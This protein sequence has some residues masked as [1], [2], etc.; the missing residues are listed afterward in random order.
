MPSLLPLSGPWQH[1]YSQIENATRLFWQQ[2]RFLDH[3]RIQGLEIGERLQAKVQDLLATCFAASPLNPCETF[4]LSAATLLYECGWQAPESAQKTVAERYH[5]SGSL[6]NQS[7]LQLPGAPRLGLAGLDSTTAEILVSLCAALGQSGPTQ[8]SKEPVAA[9]Q[10]EKARPAY[11]A[12]ILSL[13]D[14][15]L[16][17]R[18]KAAYFHRFSPNMPLPGP[19]A[20]LALHPYIELFSLTQE[21][22]SISMR[23]HP[24]DR[25]YAA[26]M[27]ACVEE[28]ILRWWAANWPWLVRDFHL[29]LSLLPPQIRIINEGIPPAPLTQT[30]PALLPYLASYQPPVLEL[31]S[32]EEVMEVWEEGQRAPE[33]TAPSAPQPDPQQKEKPARP[34]PVERFDDFYLHIDH[35][36]RIVA[37]SPQGEATARCQLEIPLALQSFLVLAR[38]NEKSAEIY[39]MLG[40]L[41]YEHL[42]P[43][44]IHTLFKQTEAVAR[45]NHRHIRIRLN[46]EANALASLPLEFLYRRDHGHFLA[47][48]PHTALARYLHVDSPRKRVRLHDG[49]LHMLLIISSPTDQPRLNVEEWRDLFYETL[50]EP[51]KQNL[52]TLDCVT[53]STYEEI[54]LARLKRPPNIV[55]FVGHGIYQEGTTSLALMQAD[56]SSWLLDGNRFA[57]MF[58]GDLDNLGL[59]CLASCESAASDDPQEFLGVTPQLLQRGIPAVIAMQYRIKVTTARLF[60]RQLYQCV[61]NAKPIDYAVQQARN[62]ISVT[63]GRDNREF[64]TPV[65]YM[66]AE[67]GAI[68]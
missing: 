24:A 30:C 14:A 52:L 55:Q 53:M 40:S 7:Y 3:G 64:A 58:L 33:L 25:D 16:V 54:T 6:I 35:Q 45:S 10:Q 28:P 56:G 17:P 19:E 23:V 20:R 31:P 34:T 9:G 66:R 48:D 41:L 47:I 65:L 39:Q 62:A 38:R 13:A 43:P 1:H 67:D 4:L 36:G 46:I 12:A 5:L 42:F 61:V 51:L 60:F 50:E 15:L 32:L 18:Q 63:Q 49:P 11:L 68:F 37:Q 57:D 27:A 2:A 8:L 21:S 22:L 44:D 29:R 26:A 59:F